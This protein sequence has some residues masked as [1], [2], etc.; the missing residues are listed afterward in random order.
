M[1]IC[2]EGSFPYPCLVCADYKVC[3]CK[4]WVQIQT[5]G[6]LAVGLGRQRFGLEP[7][8]L[9]QDLCAADWLF[10]LLSISQIVPKG[11]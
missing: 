6:G 3:T 7:R 10:C 5:E 2:L 4:G 11:S 1:E 9:P 8:F